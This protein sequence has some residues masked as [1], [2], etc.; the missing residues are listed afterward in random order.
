MNYPD[1]SIIIPAHN[2]EETLRN[3]LES[4]TRLE[5]PRDRM[6]MILINNNSTDSTEAIAR[7]FPVTLLQETRF[8][9]SYA[10]RNLGI[11]HARG[12]ILVFTDSDCVVS[13]D[14][15]IKLLE[16]FHD[17]EIGCFAGE[18][19]TY[20]PETLTETYSA[21]DEENHNQKRSLSVGYLPAANTANVAY[22]KEVFE[23]IGPFNFN[24]KSG[25]D[26]EFTWRMIQQSH[27]KIIYVP[28]AVVYHK[29]RS[30]VRSL[31]LQ[32]RK[33]G[34]GITDLLKLHPGSCAP[35]ILFVRDV[36]YY[37]YRGTVKMP[38]NVYRY[39]RGKGSN[40]DIWYFYLKALCRLGIIVG[41]IRAQGRL[42]NG[43]ISRA[44]MMQTIF[45]KIVMKFKARLSS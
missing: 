29:H 43:D 21:I 7:D 20:E 44:V 38:G 27:F 9:S 35:I 26:A 23:K 33:Y 28:E 22:R 16:F 24:L 1:I 31:Y 25:G 6:E 4:I 42:E 17:D 2:A 11:T 12:E 10:A 15:L 39:Y 30:S 19:L 3:C 37:L 41:R 14:W 34:E 36:F 45:S 13:P 8:Q 5:Y 32:H 18:I 40:L